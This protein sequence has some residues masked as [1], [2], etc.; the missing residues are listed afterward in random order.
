MLT[1]TKMGR[2]TTPRSHFMN[3]QVSEPSICCSK[4]LAMPDPCPAP[5]RSMPA[6]A[7]LCRSFVRF[8]NS[9]PSGR[10]NLRRC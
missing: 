3:S 10:R 5:A 4:T 2:L 6:R 7:R 9:N 1:L 8:F